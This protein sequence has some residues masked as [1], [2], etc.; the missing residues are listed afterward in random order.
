[1]RVATSALNTLAGH[2]PPDFRLLSAR[3]GQRFVP[4]D[5]ELI[6]PKPSGI[7]GPVKLV[8]EKVQ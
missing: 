3:Y 5:T 6:M 7:L 4:Q 1:V 8:S 2:A